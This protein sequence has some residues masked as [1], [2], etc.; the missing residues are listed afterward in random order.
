MFLIRDIEDI[1]KKQEFN[2]MSYFDSLHRD[3]DAK[4]KHERIVDSTINLKADQ[5]EVYSLVTTSDKEINVRTYPDEHVEDMAKDAK[6]TNPYPKPLLINHDIYSEP[7]GRF[8]DSWYV[9]HNDQEVRHG[10]GEIPE[11]VMD[12]LNSRKVFDEGTGSTIGKVKVNSTEVLRKIVDGTY[13]STSQGAMSQ[14][15]TCNV[16]DNSYWSYDCSHFRGKN[17]PIYSQDGKT[18]ERYERCVP[19]TGALDAVENSIVNRPANDTSSL[20]VFDKK[21]SR[22][23]NLTNIADYDDIFTV[24]KEDSAKAPVIADNKNVKNDTHKEEGL[25]DEE[26]AKLNAANKTAKETKPETVKDTKEVDMKLRNSAKRV[27]VSDMNAINVNDSEAVKAFFDELKDEEVSIALSLLEL[28]SDKMEVP[29]P[30]ET[31]TDATTTTTTDVKD[32]KAEEK[33]TTTTD[34]TEEMA[35]LRQQVKDS[36]K[37]VEALMEA[38]QDMDGVN[39][40][41]PAILDMVKGNKKTDKPKKRFNYDSY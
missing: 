21:S 7:I 16:C 40:N 8:Q 10:Q 32:E 14:S 30:A 34:E 2:D 6:W 5:F 1:A 39:N 36:N 12:E 27:F 41:I 22:V 37:K 11:A 35:T 13:Y 17:Y 19:A 31:T 9:S 26:V 18:V 29:K 28:I 25:T 33:P 23:V 24:V 20:L 15:L 4:P 38:L 3:I